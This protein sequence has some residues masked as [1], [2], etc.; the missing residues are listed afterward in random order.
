VTLEL[1]ASTFEN[2]S[3][4]SRIKLALWG[5][6]A[7]VLLL[8]AGWLWGASG[9][10]AAE[11]AERQA[12]LRLH[13]AQARAALTAARVDIFERNF[14]QASRNL[15]QAKTSLSRVATA[16][17]ES[18]GAAGVTAVREALSRSAKAQQLA[19]AV[20]QAANTEAAEAVRAL[21]RAG[22]ER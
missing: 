21:E 18:G 16:L 5:L 8:A 6:L 14:G 9:R 4:M 3:I 15:E 1:H 20:D 17:E 13:V 7:A 10:H 22:V 11:A 2:G 12:S 19:G